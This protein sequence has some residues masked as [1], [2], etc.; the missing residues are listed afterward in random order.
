R[1]WSAASC[2]AAASV[3][4]S[5]GCGD[6]RS[7][8]VRATISA[9]GSRCVI[10]VSIGTRFLRWGPIALTGSQPVRALVCSDVLVVQPPETTPVVVE[11]GDELSDWEQRVRGLGQLNGVRDLAAAVG[12]GDFV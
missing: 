2:R 12:D 11:L 1:M 10:L 9:S 8:S 6:H 7:G 4:V 5:P 3:G